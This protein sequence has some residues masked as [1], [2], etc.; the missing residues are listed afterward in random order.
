MINH[1]LMK[2]THLLGANQFYK[3][4]YKKTQIIIGHSMS[5]NLDHL[6]KWQTRLNGKYKA[7]AP[8][9]ILRDG[10]IHI[11]YDPKHHSDFVGIEEIDKHSIPIILENQGWLYKDLQN[12]RYLTWLGDIYNQE[13]EVVEKRWRNNLYWSPYTKEQMNSLI[14]LC[15]YICERFN[16]PLVALSHNTNI[17]TAGD[18]EGIL[19]RA[20]FSK[21]FSDISPAFKFDEF[22]NNLELK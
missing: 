18:F 3:T 14:N 11:H 15:K 9:T 21:Y 13:D 2:N 5:N 6:N 16:I 20:N 12:N 19:Y 17:E 22:K 4:E 7:T 10:T 8:F 1:I